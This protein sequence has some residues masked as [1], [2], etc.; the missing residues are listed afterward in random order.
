M[1]EVKNLYKR[2]HGPFGGDWVLKDVNFS[3]PRGVGT[4]S[5]SQW[6]R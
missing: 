2:Y 1:I 3:I 5:R 4:L 6:C